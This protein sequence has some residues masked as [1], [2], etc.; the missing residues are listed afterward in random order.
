VLG[1]LCGGCA[2]VHKR[3]MLLP[4]IVCHTV[5]WFHGWVFLSSALPRLPHTP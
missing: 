5:L 1:G 2:Q 4:G 3:D